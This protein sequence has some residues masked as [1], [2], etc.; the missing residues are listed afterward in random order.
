MKTW[1][2]TGATGGLASQLT[3]HLLERGDRVV[4]TTRKQGNLDKL[5]KQY[6]SQL[7]EYHLD[8]TNP[9][10]IEDI[11]TKAFDELGTIDIIVNNAAYGLYGAV[12]E[13]NDE[14]TERLFQTNLFGS[15]RVARAALPFLRKQNQGQIVQISSMAGHY[16]SPA[17]GLYSAS[18]WAVEAVFEALSQE[19][20]PFGIRTTIIEPGGIRTEF[21]G[22]KAV[23]GKEIDDYKDTPARNVTN[24]MKN[25]GLT[26]EQ[27][28]KM[29]IG[30]P[31]KMSLQII[32]SV[33]QV[34]SPLRIALGSDAYTKIHNGLTER[35]Q[36][37]EAQ[38]ELSKSTDADDE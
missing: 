20:A 3:K 35:L 34:K 16:S 25:P 10:Q 26:N 33:D 27:L 4:A 19:I 30:D 7:W 8:L 38:K 32:D 11:V 17:M 37:L 9:Q 2:I 15:I 5:K 22:D 23:F 29:I 28:K 1:F 12:E 18:K 24:F 6:D 21:A 14:Q 13:I 36:K 31:D